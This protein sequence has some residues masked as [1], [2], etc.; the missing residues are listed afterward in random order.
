M[1]DD[2]ED[3]E[4]R[5]WVVWM[6]V[7]TLQASFRSSTVED[8]M[9]ASS[10]CFFCSPTALYAVTGAASSFEMTSSS[11]SSFVTEVNDLSELENDEE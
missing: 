8:V 1:E 3:E 11:L 7:V 9:L 2:D 6:G 4:E 5:R 10:V